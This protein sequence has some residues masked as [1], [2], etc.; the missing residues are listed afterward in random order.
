ML[1]KFLSLVV[2]GIPGATLGFVSFHVFHVSLKIAGGDECPAPIGFLRKL[3]MRVV[4][5]MAL[6]KTCKH[7]QS[8]EERSRKDGERL[9][10]AY[11]HAA[12]KQR[13]CSCH[14]ESSCSKATFLSAATK[15]EAA[16]RSHC[17]AVR[18]ELGQKREKDGTV[19]GRSKCFPPAHFTP[20]S[21]QPHVT[22][23]ICNGT[24]P[25]VC[26]SLLQSL[27]PLR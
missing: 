13:P 18:S 8:W 11:E 10:A 23:Q 24:L 4:F 15:L 21:L 3:L 6:F 25:L 5:L 2:D 16:E 27:L 7:Q 17:E 20:S 12:G 1:C 9:F 19:Q 26:H 22:A 14:K